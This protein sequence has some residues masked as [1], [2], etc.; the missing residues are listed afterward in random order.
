MK[1]ADIHPTGKEKLKDMIPQ[2]AYNYLANVLSATVLALII[3]LI[4]SSGNP[5]VGEPTWFRGAVMGFWVWLG[6]IVTSTSMD[7]IW[8]GRKLKL[9]LFESACSLVVMT[10]MGAM[11]AVWR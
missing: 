4:F 7:V 11:L 8:M 3:G 10:V 1:L 2:M 5:N 6:F 9:W